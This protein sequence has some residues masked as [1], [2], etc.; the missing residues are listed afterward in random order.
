MALP[1][2]NPLTPIMFQFTEEELSL[3]PGMA[4]ALI[5][6]HV[7]AKLQQPSS[8]IKASSSSDMD[9]VPTEQAATATT[10]GSDHE[11]ALHTVAGI[12]QVVPAAIE[13]GSS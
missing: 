9:V 8:A 1:D 3:S 2:R 4:S 11:Q 5:P 7:V 10:S 12:V 13:E 6:P